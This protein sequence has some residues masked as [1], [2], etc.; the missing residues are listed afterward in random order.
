MTEKKPAASMKLSRTPRATPKAKTAEDRIE[1][2]R[3]GDTQ[4]KNAP[5]LSK[6]ATV[7]K[8]YRLT[9]RAL[10][11]ITLATNADKAAGKRA[12]MTGKV[13]EAIISAYAH[14]ETDE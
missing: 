7:P 3:A 8:T 13:E 12:S 2:I 10:N 1:A 14:L 9:E 6:L 4:P 5:E 11:L